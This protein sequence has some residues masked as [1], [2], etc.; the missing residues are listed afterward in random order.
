MDISGTGISSTITV[1]V[2]PRF[3]V[4]T[5]LS[6]KWREI[7]SK[8]WVA[9]DRGTTSDIYGAAI[10]VYGKEAA[11]DELI[12]ALQDN[13]AADSHILSLSDFFSTENIFGVDVDH[14]G[15]ISATVI[16]FPERKQKTFKGWGVDLRLRAL[17]PSFTGSAS[18]PTLNGLDFGVT[19]KRT[20]NV[21]KFDDYSGNYS[22][23]DRVYDSGI[24]EGVFT[25]TEANMKSLRRYIASN[26]TGDYVLQ[27][28][29][30]VAEPFGPRS[31]AGY[32]YNVK[33]IDWEDMG[34]FGLK[35]WKIRLKFA[36]QHGAMQINISDSVTASE[37]I[38]L[39][40]A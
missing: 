22:Y 35:W 38:E 34:M 32:P 26:R 23:Q 16:S 8:K 39:S 33:L 7:A 21:N 4:M 6:M 20:W 13:R 30:G 19:A 11:I 12:D 9:T 5:K 15:S 37:S 27:D 14:S 25:L 28:T 36:E 31:T 40:I 24:F 2:L 3:K 17:S 29:F 10:S 18:F 1:K